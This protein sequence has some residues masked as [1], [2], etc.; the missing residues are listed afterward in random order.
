MTSEA[1][2]MNVGLVGAGTMGAGMVVNLRRNGFPVAFL[3]RESERGRAVSGRLIQAGATAAAGL[4]ELA[5]NRDVILLCLPDS[6]AVESVLDVSGGLVANLRPGSIVVDCSTSDPESTRR[7]AGALA[8]REI[9][10][11]D[12]PLTGSRA[13]AEA[14]TLS[15]LGAGPRDAFERVRPVLAGFAANLFHL[16]DSGAGHAAKLINNFLGQLALVGLCEVWPT[17]DKY[18]IDR[19]G[20][21][22]AI[23][24]SGGNSATFRGA[25]PRLRSRDFAL[26]FAQRLAGKDMSYVAGLVHSAGGL[27]PLAECLAGIYRS[28]IAQGYG[29]CDVTELV[30]CYES[31]VDKTPAP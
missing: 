3:A 31:A 17:L 24:A 12:G 19:Q 2:T 18:G 14:G 29:D 5:W 27:A 25:Y 20:L 7:L 28:S 30:R 13:Q 23:S 4:D 16:G 22:D 6:P 9:T 21:Y 10:L 11:L 1:T 8:A 26:N 15:V